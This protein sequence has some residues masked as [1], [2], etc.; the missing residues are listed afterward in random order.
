[1]ANPSGSTQDSKAWQVVS[2][3]PATDN[4]WRIVSQVPVPGS[5]M[6]GGPKIVGTPM[7]Q[8]VPVEALTP[9][10]MAARRSAL[11]SYA[12]SLANLMRMAGGAIDTGVQALGLPKMLMQA[13]PLN[14]IVNPRAADESAAPS[15]SELAQ[16][17]QDIKSGNYLGA[18]GHALGAIPMIGP[19]AASIGETLGGNA[20]EMP[21]N[22]PEAFKAPDPYR[23]AGMM[24]GG[25]ALG[26][27]GEKVGEM[28]DEAQKNA[29]PK[30][31]KQVTS[32]ARPS[33][34]LTSWPQFLDTM[35]PDLADMARWAD[36]AGIP[37]ETIDDQIKAIPSAKAALMTHFNRAFEPI[38]QYG[39][40]SGPAIADQIESS[41]AASARSPE[42]A[43]FL[44]QM[45]GKTDPGLV[46]DVNNRANAWREMGDVP[47]EYAQAQRV[48]DN[49]LLD[50]YYRKNKIKAAHARMNPDIGHVVAEAE[51]LRDA[52]NNKTQ[53]LSG[54]DVGQLMRRWGALNSLEEALLKRKGILDREAPINLPEQLGTSFGTARMAYGLA[55][56]LP[57]L[58]I[59][60]LIEGGLMPYLR[61][62]NSPN[63]LIRS[64]MSTL[65][66]RQPGYPVQMPK[67]APMLA[68]P[69]SPLV[70]GP[71]PDASYA[72]GIPA[73]IDV[74]YPGQRALPPGQS[75][76]GPIPMPPSSLSPVAGSE[77]T[78]TGGALGYGAMPQPPLKYGGSVTGEEPETAVS[79]N[80]KSGRIQ[81]QYL[82]TSKPK[83]GQ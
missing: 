62:W 37:I 45:R 76:Y 23:A 16:A 48:L 77:A 4:P 44:K 69:E 34:E 47:L 29:V 38:K 51:A 64:A 27:A 53:Q 8:P 42:A 56:G 3:T 28:Y 9:E 26:K 32:A 58:A 15:K 39:T 31:K 63:R 72:V 74:Q 46:N 78:P 30:A 7:S 65:A 54:V 81:R 21:A 82:G 6:L 73:G 10:Q 20:A 50:S 60:G 71:S 14:M 33:S 66:D 68:L 61:R 24:L 12:P 41:L 5:T 1:M 79:R 2:Q 83:K 43:E 80:K 13:N 57:G 17:G 55:Q 25:L 22:N 36:Q 11:P 67:A 59:E 70:A 75:P 40:V 35:V 52:I 18:A 49:S 19:W